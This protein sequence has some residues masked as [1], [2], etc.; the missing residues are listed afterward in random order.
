VTRLTATGRAAFAAA[1]RGVYDKWAAV[2]GAD[3]VTATEA[4]VKGINR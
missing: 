1:T 3:L 2:I 4:A